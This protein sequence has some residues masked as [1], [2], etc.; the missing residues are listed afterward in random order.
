MDRLANTVLIYCSC[1]LTIKF[2]D[3]SPR[4]LPELQLATART[5]RRDT[6]HL[7]DISDL[8]NGHLLLIQGQLKGPDGR[9]AQEL[10]SQIGFYDNILTGISSTLDFSEL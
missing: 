6:V 5:I 7:R 2:R 8:M 3:V 10:H 9:V 4:S 1:V